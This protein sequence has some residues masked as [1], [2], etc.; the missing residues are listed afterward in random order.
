MSK[1]SRHIG[2][3]IGLFILALAGLTAASFALFP[4]QIAPQPSAIGGPFKLTSADGQRI[5]NADLAGHPYLIFFGYT[6]CPDFCPTALLDI[7]QVFK[8]LGEDK[9]IAAV[10]ITI[11]PER[12][13]PAVIKDYLQ[14]FDPRIIGLSGNLAEIE[15]VEKTFRVYAKKV[16][17]PNGAYT[18]DH[19]G[20][21]YL[22]DKQGHFA[23]AFNLNASPDAA[24]R[25]LR[26]YL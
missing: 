16:P 6:H 7:S 17:G 24:A 1:S 12:D 5:G 22:M 15:A 10:F 4:N 26:P 13:S 21:V 20:I 3:L 2:I 9:K 8:A 14:D 11:D 18:M 19:S 25:Q 23:Q